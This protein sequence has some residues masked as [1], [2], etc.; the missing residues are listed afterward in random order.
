M[1]GSIGQ[2]A[3]HS[4]GSGVEGGAKA[5]SGFATVAAVA[6]PAASEINLRRFM[7]VIFR[8]AKLCRTFCCQVVRLTPTVVRP[9]FEEQQ[10]DGRGTPVP[11]QSS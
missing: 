7:V 8:F 3:N 2:A 4:P 1:V 11:L 6:A 9:P 5:I 10:R